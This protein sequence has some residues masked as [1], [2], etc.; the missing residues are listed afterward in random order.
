MCNVIKFEEEV[1]FM[2]LD[3]KA[4]MPTRAHNS[5]AG[6]D[7]VATSKEYDEFDNVVYGTG[8]AIELPPGYVA[9]LFPRSSNRKTNLTLTNSVGV[10]DS[11]Y[12]GEIKAV[13]HSINSC[14]S[15][16]ALFRA[17]ISKFIPGLKP[18]AKQI[19]IENVSNAYDVGDRIAQLI[20]LR[21]PLITFNEKESLSDSDRGTNAYGSTGK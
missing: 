5:D 20:I 9:L 6:Y 8:I 10:I 15:F 4:V 3:E 16:G 14:L 17:W 21:L 12:R 13:F 7:L 18:F 19:S 2:K 1:G 11:G